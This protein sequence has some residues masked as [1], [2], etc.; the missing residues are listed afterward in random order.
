MGNLRNISDHVRPATDTSTDVRLVPYRKLGR[1]RPARSGVGQE[2]EPDVRRWNKWHTVRNC[3]P[4]VR[5]VRVRIAEPAWTA[6]S[7]SGLLRECGERQ[8]HRP[9]TCECGLR[10]LQAVQLEGE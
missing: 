9:Q 4:L 1:R 3:G 10:R 2:L 8:H 7:R 6:Q 5:S